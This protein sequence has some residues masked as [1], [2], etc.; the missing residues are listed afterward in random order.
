MGDQ[1][2]LFWVTADGAAAV[3]RV[4]TENSGEIK[5]ECPTHQGKAAKVSKCHGNWAF[6]PL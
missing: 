4:I 3:L 2:P 5:G 1:L 6:G